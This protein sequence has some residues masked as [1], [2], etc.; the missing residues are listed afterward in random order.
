MPNVG[1][2]S[3][4]DKLMELH[5]ASMDALV[6]GSAPAKPLP[7]TTP[8]PAI[9]PVVVCGSVLAL[10]GVGR[11]RT[12]N[13]SAANTWR[14]FVPNIADALDLQRFDELGKNADL[15]LNLWSAFGLACERGDSASVAYHAKQITI[16]SRSALALVK[17]LGQAEPDDARQ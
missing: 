4:P 13:G 2:K 10:F 12:R 15:A 7:R 8:T 14:N 5:A 1:E 9:I 3:F 6:R 16:L 11:S 17:R